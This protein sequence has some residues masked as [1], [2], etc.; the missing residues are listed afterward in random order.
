MKR[1]DIKRVSGNTLARRS[2]VKATITAAMAG[3]SCD[4]SLAGSSFSSSAVEFSAYPSKPN[5]VFTLMLQKS[6]K[7]GLRR[8]QSS[9]YKAD[10]KPAQG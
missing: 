9:R 1:I 8:A 7:F 6:Q 10:P 2:F 3:A 4:L 5:I